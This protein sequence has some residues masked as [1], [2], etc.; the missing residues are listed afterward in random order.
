[1][2]QA[3]HSAPQLHGRAVCYAACASGSPAINATAASTGA[4]ASISAA[5]ERALSR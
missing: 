2:S 5:T 3:A 1:M 4:S